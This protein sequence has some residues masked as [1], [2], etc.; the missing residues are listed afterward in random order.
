MRPYS[1][2]E[3]DFV[4]KYIKDL[5]TKNFARLVKISKATVSYGILFAKKKNGNLRLY[6]NY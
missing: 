4:K 3:E 1:K 6:I 5:V 2:K